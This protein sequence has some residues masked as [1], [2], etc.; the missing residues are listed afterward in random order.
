ML[1]HVGDAHFGRHFV[2]AAGAHPDAQGGAFQIG[3]RVGDDGQA[4]GKSGYFYVHA[5]SLEE[6]NWRIKERLLGRISSLSGSVQKPLQRSRHGRRRAGGARHGIGEFGGMG[7]GEHHHRLLAET[8][9]ARGADG[10]G[11]MR[12]DDAARR[13]GD[14]VDG[15]EGVVIVAGVGS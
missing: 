14:G 2:A 1:Q 10:D 5:A 6:M 15:R 11:G 8:E 3:H 4:I 7:G 13:S 12:I 9:L